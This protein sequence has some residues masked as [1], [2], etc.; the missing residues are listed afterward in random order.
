[1][2]PSKRNKTVFIPQISDY[3]STYCNCGSRSTWISSFIKKVVSHS[4]ETMRSLLLVLQWKDFC[5]WQELGSPGVTSAHW[6]IPPFTLLLQ[7]TTLRRQEGRDQLSQ[8]AASGKWSGGKDHCVCRF[9]FN[10]VERATAINLKSLGNMLSSSFGYAYLPMFP[11][12]SRLL[13]LLCWRN[14]YGSGHS[15]CADKAA[16]MSAN[17]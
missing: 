17:W 10:R 14:P 11:S 5:V 3:G 1:M 8:A 2:E 13:V 9:G 15:I 7:T 4:R 16:V 12:W 6:H